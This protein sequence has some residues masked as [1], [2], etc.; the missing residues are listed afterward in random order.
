MCTSVL[1]KCIFVY[2]LHAWYTQ[3]PEKDVESLGTR[4]SWCV[5][6]CWESNPGPWEEKPVLFTAGP[7]LLP[8]KINF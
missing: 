7:S 6:G 2:Y 3:R 8:L 1:G 4:V 5:G